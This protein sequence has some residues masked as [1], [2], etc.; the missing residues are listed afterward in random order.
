[1]KK[2]YFIAL[3]RAEKPFVS[4]LSVGSFTPTEF[5]N[6]D[7]NKNP[8]VRAEDEIPSY[9][10]GVSTV[11]IVDRRLVARDA[12]E[13]AIY[14]EEYNIKIALFNNRNRIG[15]INGSSF[16]FDGND[17][18][19]DEVSRL[20][21]SMIALSVD[22]YSIQTMSGSKYALRDTSKND[23]LRAYYTKLLLISKHI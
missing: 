18:P 13:M 8:L 17:F 1:M 6:S 19:M 14:E 5:E 12:A 22:D 4:W 21:Y 2:T 23:F 15:D 7:Y 10:F 9:A 16:N 3:E 20:Y 11:H